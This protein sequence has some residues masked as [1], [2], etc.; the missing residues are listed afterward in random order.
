MR[1][2]TVWE[3]MLTVVICCLGVIYDQELLDVSLKTQATLVRRPFS[4]ERI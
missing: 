1:G 4:A 2:V 3:V